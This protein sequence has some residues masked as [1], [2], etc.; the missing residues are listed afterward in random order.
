MVGN[1]AFDM[2]LI[3]TKRTVEGGDNVGPARSD[4]VSYI[5]MPY[6]F[7]QEAP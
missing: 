3:S 7:F 4:R 6:L 5:K 2:Y 1:S